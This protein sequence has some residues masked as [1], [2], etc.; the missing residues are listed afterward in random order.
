M[1]LGEIGDLQLARGGSAAKSDAVR[2][3]L[4]P[5]TVER[6]NFATKFLLTF[7]TFLDECG[8]CEQW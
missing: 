6:L 8:G 1:R 2:V 7:A 4:Q 3:E 5:L